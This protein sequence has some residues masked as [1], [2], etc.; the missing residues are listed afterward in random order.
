[1]LLGTPSDLGVDLPVLRRDVGNEN[2]RVHFHRSLL[3]CG[4]GRSWSQESLRNQW[5]ARWAYA[6]GVRRS[7]AAF[8]SVLFLLVAPGVVAGLVPWLLTGWRSSHPA[9]AVVV[10]GSVLIALGTGVLLHA[11]GRFVFEGR[12]TPAP[13]APTE[14][15]VVGGLYRHVRNPMYL[16]VGATIVGQAL[17]LG[18]PLL[19]AYAAVFGLVVATF[20]WSYEE[21]TLSARY[22]EQY[23]AY[24]RSACEHE[25]PD[26][27]VLV[28]QRVHGLRAPLG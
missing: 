9:T 19:L 10:L 7:Q 13:V 1:M 20:V 28:A 23:A 15:L 3:A 6:R 27:P 18:R 11:F 8:G 14:R 17:V 24:R 5:L 4:H 22:G 12:G 21:P 26:A 2:T 25:V 16:A